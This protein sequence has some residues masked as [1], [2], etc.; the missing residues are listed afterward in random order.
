[1][2]TDPD[3]WITGRATG[4]D[5]FI[6]LTGEHP[7]NGETQLAQLGAAGLI[8]PTKL[9]YVRNHGRVPLFD[10]DKHVVRVDKMNRSLNQRVHPFPQDKDCKGQ[11]QWH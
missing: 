2:T 9:H 6:R 1:M 7:L 3:R 4:E 8:T 5:G 10:P 11:G